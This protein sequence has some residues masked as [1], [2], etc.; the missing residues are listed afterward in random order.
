MDELDF[1]REEKRNLTKA[2]LSDDTVRCRVSGTYCD[3]LYQVAD[4]IRVSKASVSLQID[5]SADVSI[6]TDFLVYCRCGGYTQ[7][8][9]SCVPSKQR[10]L[11]HQKSTEVI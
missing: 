6:C 7:T 1:E 10:T 8:E 5:E 11:G 4:E 9:N 3:I 2:S